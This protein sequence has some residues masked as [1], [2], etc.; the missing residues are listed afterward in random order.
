[1]IQYIALF[2]AF[3]ATLVKLWKEKGTFTYVFIIVT[4]ILSGVVS[5]LIAFFGGFLFPAEAVSIATQAEIVNVLLEHFFSAFIGSIV[6]PIALW[7][8][9]VKLELERK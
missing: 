2:I 8:S 6:I 5:L 1:M 4:M 9:T 3:F 7:I